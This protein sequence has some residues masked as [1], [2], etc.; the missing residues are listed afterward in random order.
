MVNIIHMAHPKCPLCSNSKKELLYESSLLSKSPP[1]GLFNCTSSHYGMHGPIYHCS[2]CSLVFIVDDTNVLQIVKSYQDAQDPVYLAEAGARVKTFQR[3]LDG[4]EPF[5]GQRLLDVGAYTGL[6]V[7][8]AR[9]SGCVTEGIEP[10]SWAIGKAKSQYQVKLTRGI[11]RAGYFKPNSFDVVTLW[12]VIEHFVD[13]KL[14]MK[15]CYAYLKKRGWIAMSTINVEAPAAKIL[16][17]RWPWLMQMHRV[18]FSPVTMTKMLAQ[19]GFTNISFRPHIRYISL[20]YLWSSFIQVKLPD[21][22]GKIII[23]FY[24][25]DLF[26]VYAQKI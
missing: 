26:D 19:A 23:P 7:Y 25:G 4:I 11:L 8:L 16:G 9:K 1:S 10:S 17:S 24:I 18:Y 6:F 5:K 12:D 21:I 22:L 20:G 13:P 15:I 14:A 2:K 3:Q